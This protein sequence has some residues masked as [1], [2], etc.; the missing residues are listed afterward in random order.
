ME[1]AAEC[2]KQKLPEVHLQVACKACITTDK[3][4]KDASFLYTLYARL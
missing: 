4:T 1:Q 2:Q 3:A